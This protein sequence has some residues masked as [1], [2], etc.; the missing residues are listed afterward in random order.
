[1]ADAAVSKPAKLP[2]AATPT[3]PEELHEQFVMFV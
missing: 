2:A 1:M 3:N